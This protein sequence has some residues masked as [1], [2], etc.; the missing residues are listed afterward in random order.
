[1]ISD[2]NALY[3]LA[4]GIPI[5]LFIAILIILFAAI[6]GVLEFKEALEALQYSATIIITY[7]SAILGFSFS[8]GKRIKSNKE[9]EEIKN[10]IRPILSIIIPTSMIVFLLALNILL[11]FEGIRFSDYKLASIIITWV[12]TGFTSFI[13]GRYFSIENIIE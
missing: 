9:S 5:F 6:R 2:K 13:I 10:T 3:F 12:L 8:K 7:V 11:L 1:M 4:I